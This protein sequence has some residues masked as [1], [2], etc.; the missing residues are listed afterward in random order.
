MGYRKKFR[1]LFLFTF[2]LP[3]FLMAY[4]LPQKAYA[5]EEGLKVPETTPIEAGSFM[6]G[7]DFYDGEKRPGSIN[8]DGLTGATPFK[9]S[10]AHE[11]T[12]S[13]YHIGK[14][15][16]TNE[17]YAEFVDAEGY[18][19]K[20]FWLIDSD[21][22]ED[23]EVGW[24]WK[25]E[26]GR[27][28]PRYRVNYETGETAGWD[29][30]KS[31]YWQDDPY[32]NQATTP[33][34]GVA[35]YEAYAYCKWLSSVT[36]DTYR[37]PTEAEWEY[38]ARGP[39]SNTFPWGDDYLTAEEM[40]GKPGSGS[41]CNCNMV[42]AESEDSIGARGKTTPIGSYPE[43]DSYFGVC[44]MAGNV[45]EWTKDW[46]QMLYYPQRIRKGEVTDPTGPSVARPPLWGISFSPYWEEPCRTVR[47]QGYNQEPL[48]EEM[49]FSLL[50]KGTYVL[51]CSHRMAI[52]RFGGS[53]LSGF[54]VVKEEK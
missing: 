11:V 28:A 39:E 12:M 43:S 9:E 30:S 40:C 35:W 2:L 32:S 17:E 47:S 6:M 23:A 4:A 5:Q 42:M 27:T 44:D 29:L 1:V 41:M 21:D 38:A 15:E 19:N 45:A 36:G 51:R 18:D 46:F 20:E 50:V 25:Q 13:S 34:L 37:L 10:P 8:L 48:G 24:N 14:Y 3:L 26:E 31:P 52:A 22:F 33:V 53:Y 16:V 7:M 54:R 49:N